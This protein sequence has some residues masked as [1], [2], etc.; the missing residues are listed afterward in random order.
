M[1][2]IAGLSVAANIFQ[3]VGFADA[4]FRAGK[5]LYDLFD[6]ARSASRNISLL[7]QELQALLSVIAFVRVVITEHT[8]SPFARDDGHTLPNVRTILTL[9]EQDF[10]HLRGLLG[11]IIGSGR[12]G[13]LSL[14]N[15]RWALNDHEIAISKHRLAQYTQN[16]NATLSVIGR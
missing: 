2:A 4:V 8:S 9:I 5:S 13:W 15:V 12:E 11:N 3:V 10:R 16:L 14:F 1:S 6:R 7:L